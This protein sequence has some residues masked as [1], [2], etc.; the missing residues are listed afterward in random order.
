M[1]LSPSRHPSSYRDPSGFVFKYNSLFYRQVNKLYAADYESFMERL[2]PKLVEKRM[3]IPHEEV[4][5][6]FESSGDAYKMI[7]PEQLLFISYPYEWSFD[8]LK[9]AA[10][11]TLNIQKTAMA[12]SMTL[13]DATPYNIQWKDGKMIFIDTLSFE[14]YD[15][16]LPWIAYRQ[17]CEMFLAPLVLMH[18]SRKPLQE[19]ML[20]YPE[21]IPLSV[22]SAMLPL[23]SLF[24]L[25]I[26]L[27]LHLNANYAGKR[28][29]EPKGGFTEK[30]LRDI[31]DSLY[32]AVTSSRLENK[33]T[34]GAYYEEARERTDYIAFKKQVVN[35]WTI[36]LQGIDEV[37]DLGGNDGSFSQLLAMQGK[38]VVCADFDHM[39]INS[40]YKNGR[41]TN[42]HP[43]LLDFSHPSP[44]IGFNN[45]ERMSF[46]ERAASDLVL[47]L[48]LIHH[49]CLGRNVPLGALAG[50]LSRISKNLI[51]EFIPKDDSKVKE[52]LETRT[53]PFSDYDRES[54]EIAFSEY[55]NI[56]RS[57]P[58]ASSG[59]ML[60]LMGRKP[61]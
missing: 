30:K 60:Y 59:R 21:G 23:K 16:S 31:I 29:V 56:I 15:P 50:S 41:A 19:L 4:I 44:A 36:D 27:H 5:L 3:I 34:W 38:R 20:S 1:K 9:D 52:M 17:F 25:H 8:M 39:A 46:H 6:P 61:S 51:I 48:A 32:S 22:V 53:N 35:E 57:V 33:T 12:N 14:P 2:Y 43:L 45:T 58:L 49:I 28:S 10:L 42:V 26:Y 54:F 7:L 13:K 47:F 55:F 18:Y 37:L 40:L 24:R 11:L